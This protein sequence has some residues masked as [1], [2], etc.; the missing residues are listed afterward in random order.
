MSKDSQVIPFQ[1]EKLNVRV[2]MIDGEPWF[3][4]KDLAEAL[5]YRDA[6]DMIRNV[7]DDMGTQIVRTPGGDQ[8]MRVINESGLYAAIIKSR[9]PEAKRFKKW[10]T[11]EVL[12]SIRKT[13]SYGGRTGRLSLSRIKC[14]PTM[15]DKKRPSS[16]TSRK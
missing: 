9:K 4:G 5:V 3:V 15:R 14:P 12:P 6:Y 11:S 13:G 1:F 16:A 2:V 10:V 7:A 8:Q